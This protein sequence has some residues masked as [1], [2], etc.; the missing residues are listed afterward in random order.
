MGK[1]KTRFFCKNLAS[2]QSLVVVDSDCSVSLVHQSGDPPG[3]NRINA[4]L[5]GFDVELLPSKGF[6][7]G[8][9]F[10]DGKPVFWNP[11]IG[12]C[13]PDT[14]DLFSDEIAINGTPSPGFT[15]LKTFCGGI[16]FYG[17]RNWG[18]PSVD[19]KT[20]FHHP[21]HGET[22]NIPVDHC[23]VEIN[24]REIRLS[25]S[26]IY[27]EFPCK[28]AGTWYLKGR[29]LFEVER[30]VVIGRNKPQLQIIDRIKNIRN[31]PLRPDWG[32][33]ITFHP[34]DGSQLVI[35][36]ASAENRSGNTVPGSFDRWSPATNNK[37][38]EET[39]IIHKGLK[40][41]PS[42]F[43]NLGYALVI[44]PEN[45]G[46]KISF[47]VSPYFQ[48]WFCKGGAQSKEFT[49]VSD[50]KALYSRNWDGMGIEFGSSA[51]D[52]NGNTDMSVPGEVPLDPGSSIEIPLVI[53]F[54]D[55]IELQQLSEEIRKINENRVLLSSKL[56]ELP[57]I[58]SRIVE[59]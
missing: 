49:R 1:E 39:G 55:G 10:R 4:S 59:Q 5:N 47:P 17:L 20:N 3:V 54:A 52:H 29:E 23:D 15:F 48:T 34:S 43:G 36:S 25:A 6:S 32:Y 11:P 16:E 42:D 21:I 27:R 57:Y 41:K 30:R 58:T 26:F 53:D 12:I 24:D 35:P 56:P 28:P 46:C 8:Q 50:G 7:I 38:R 19:E 31:K 14:L 22:S 44:H 37:M 51:L 33:H 45:T 18:M 2:N 13:D 40:T 9:V